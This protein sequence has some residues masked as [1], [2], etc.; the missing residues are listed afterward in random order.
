MVSASLSTPAYPAPAESI[1]Q[2]T[3]ETIA[4]DPPYLPYAAA[5]E[6]D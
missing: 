5:A 6:R 3:R 1:S 4:A 2:K